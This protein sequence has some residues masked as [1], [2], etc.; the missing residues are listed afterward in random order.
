M[1]K[2]N[3][4]IEEFKRIGLNSE[5]E[6]ELLDYMEKNLIEFRQKREEVFKVSSEGKMDLAAK[7]LVN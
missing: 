6:K 1:E 5:K 3:K 2:F 7:N 4:D